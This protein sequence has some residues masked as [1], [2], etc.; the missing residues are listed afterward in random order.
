MLKS[1]RVQNLVLIENLELQFESGFTALTGE[2]G[3]GKSILMGALHLILGG[4]AKPD[5]VRQGADKVRVEAVFDAPP[6]RAFTEALHRLEIDPDDEMILEREINTQGKSRCRIN[7]HVVT[8]GALEEVG[9]FLADLHGQHAQQSLL[10]PATHSTFLDA[11]AGIESLVET[12]HKHYQAWQGVEAKLRDADL[13]ARRVK[14]QLEFIQFQVK[15]LEKAA[16]SPGEEDRIEADLKLQ[17]GHEKVAQ[18]LAA[19]LGHLEGEDGDILGHLGQLQRELQAL[20]KFLDPNP[21]ASHAESLENSRQNLMDLRG[22]LRGYRLPASADPAKL[23]QLNAKLALIQRLKSKYGTDLDGLVALRDRR[24]KELALVENADQESTQLKETCAQAL[25]DAR[26]LASE[27]KSKRQQAAKDFEKAVHAHLQGLS[28][29]QARFEARLVP[30]ASL[31]DGEAGLG[32]RGSESVEFFLAANAGESSKPMAAVAS[33][34][35]ISRVMLALKAALAAGDTRPLLVFDELDTG[36]GGVTAH[37]VGQLLKDLAKHHQLLVI[38]H[39]HQ[40]AAQ[41]DHQQQVRKTLEGG[42]TTTQVVALTQKERVAELARM[43]GDEGSKSA[44][45]HAKELLS[46]GAG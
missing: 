10:R 11:F 5:L 6:L 20:G 9:G 18:G 32:P 42:R 7:G 40:V 36:I 45:K 37:K 26:K 2:T 24:K 22:A 38:T 41:A 14:E 27:L 13:E 43:L 12:Y 31:A 1:L 29:E 39:L 44:L 21:F 8:L 23:D 19:A 17:S 33:G 3:A 25:R 4:R 30:E 16:L 15:E 28:M 34:G 46:Q 35:E